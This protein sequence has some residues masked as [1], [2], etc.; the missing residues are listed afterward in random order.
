[1]KFVVTENAK[2]AINLDWV[3]YLVLRT[4]K[5]REVPDGQIYSL[6]AKIGDTEIFLTRFRRYYDHSIVL[7]IERAVLSAVLKFIDS[8]D[9]KVLYIDK[10]IAELANNDQAVSLAF[11]KSEVVPSN[12]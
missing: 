10:L 2:M 3:P 11:K 9:S 7:T 4:L 5:D 12:E 1:M 6:V 8:G